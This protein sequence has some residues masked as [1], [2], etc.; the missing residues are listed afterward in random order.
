MKSFKFLL[1]IVAGTT[2]A[3][4]LYFGTGLHPIWPLL[5]FAPIPVIAIAPQL[6]ASRA[7]ALATVAWF[8]GE[9]NLWKHLAYGIGLPWRAGCYLVSR[10]RN[11]FCS[12]C[13]VRAQ[14]S[15]TRLVLSRC[16]RVSILLGELRIS[17]RERFAT[18]HLRESRLYA[19]ELSASYPNSIFDRNLG[20]Q[21]HRLLVCRSD[22]SPF[23]RGRG[24][25]AT[26]HGRHCDGSC[27]L[28]SLSFWRFAIAIESA[29]SITRRHAHREGRADESL[30]RFRT[31]DA[32]IA[33]RICR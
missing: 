11:C 9:M 13:F 27:P 30:S 25:A 26:A 31:A 1:V 28:C 17:E 15:S 2:T 18:Q 23:E 29:D 3:A 19:D 16:D 24:S 4:L 21:L 12:R 14:L 33:A 6:R 20:H 10:S 8:F 22:R 7:F 5:W 32:G